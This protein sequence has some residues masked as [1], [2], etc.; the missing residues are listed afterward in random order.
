MGRKGDINM[1]FIDVHNHSIYGI[2]DGAKTKEET[3]NMLKMAEKDNIERLILTPHYKEGTV[4]NNKDIILSKFEETQQL[5]DDNKLNIKIYPGCEIYLSENTSDLINNNVFQTMNNTK[6]IL[7]ETHRIKTYITFNIEEELYNL[8]IDGYKPIIAHPERYQIIK[9]NPD[10]VLDLVNEGY[11]IQINASSLVDSRRTHYKV[12]RKLL[13]NNLVHFIA[14][15]AH[16]SN[17]RQPILSN[18]YEL[19]KRRYGLNKANDLFYNNSLKIINNENIEIKKQ[20]K[21]K[22]RSLF[23]FK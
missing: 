14:T 5:I 11:L 1:K 12:A 10:R 16:N 13:D 23:F 21:F 15:D 8:A 4:E 3:L 19:I 6:Y 20:K 7:V 9:E 2:D 17:R 22:K 18:A